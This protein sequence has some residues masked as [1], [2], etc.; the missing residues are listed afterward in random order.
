MDEPRF[1]LISGIGENE[2][3]IE[4]F[5]PVIPR[6]GENISHESKEISGKVYRIDNVFTPDQFKIYV[7]II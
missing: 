2:E 5:C 7:Y 4:L 1:T 3:S 6:I